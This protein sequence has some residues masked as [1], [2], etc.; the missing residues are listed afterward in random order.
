MRATKQAVAVLRTDGNSS[1][2]EATVFDG[3]LAIY[4]WSKAFGRK[5]TKTDFQV[6]Y[7][8][9]GILVGFFKRESTA[10]Q[11]IEHLL[12]YHADA[13]ASADTL[14][15]TKHTLQE[16]WQGFYRR[17]FAAFPVPEEK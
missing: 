1:T 9:T 3:L 6:A 7:V 15:A 10:K 4:H 5:P 11:Y 8:P 13:L 2:V 14:E 17:D 12:A 16:A